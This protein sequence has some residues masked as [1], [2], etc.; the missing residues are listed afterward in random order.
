[1]TSEF[2]SVCSMIVQ[3]KTSTNSSTGG[4]KIYTA[5][6]RC[7][8]RESHRKFDNFFHRELADVRVLSSRSFSRAHVAPPDRSSRDL[9]GRHNIHW[10][11]IE[12]TRARGKRYIGH[13]HKYRLYARPCSTQAFQPVTAGAGAACGEFWS[14]PILPL[15]L[16][17]VKFLEVPVGY[18]P[19]PFI[20]FL[21]SLVLADGSLLA[22]H[23]TSASYDMTK[24]VTLTGTVTEF[25]WSNPHCQ[26]FF[27]VKDED[28]N[29]VHWAAENSSP[30]VLTNEGWTRNTLK[31][32]DQIAITLN[33]S[34]A[35]TKVGV[36]SKIVLSDGRVLTRHPGE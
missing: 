11:P 26:L 36:I 14:I 8:S 27:D 15:Y 23:G 29:V 33:P 1:M 34:K 20:V 16:P 21:A 30:G 10:P 28:G 5:N 31:P 9:T 4:N 12:L 17:V 22:H 2:P 25:V 7:A 19:I 35:A 32:G 3:R 13:P 24:Q 18:R 6:L